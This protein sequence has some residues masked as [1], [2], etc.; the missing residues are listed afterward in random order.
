MEDLTLRDLFPSFP[1]K[2]FVNTFLFL[3]K[4]FSKSHFLFAAFLSSG[5]LQAAAQLPWSQPQV[6]DKAEGLSTIE[7]ALST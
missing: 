1:P 5:A 2:W 6:E 7:R 3:E 4:S